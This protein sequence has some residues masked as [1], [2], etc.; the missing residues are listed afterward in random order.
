MK[1]GV[2]SAGPVG[3]GDTGREELLELVGRAAKGLTAGRVVTAA[4]ECGPCGAEGFEWAEFEVWGREYYCF[5]CLLPIGV[6]DGD[7]QERVLPGAGT[8]WW[9]LTPEEPAAYVKCPAGH[10]AFQAAVALTLSEDGQV[11]SLSAGLRCP[12]DGG[13]HLLLDNEPVTPL[14]T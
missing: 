5:G 3:G 4:V 9:R 13:L 8:A 7:V 11:Q 10:M 14:P 6:L 2:W 1:P 12:E